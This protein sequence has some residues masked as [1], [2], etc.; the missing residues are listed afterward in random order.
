MP[1]K[2]R[3][4]IWS[5]VVCRRVAHRTYSMRDVDAAELRLTCTARGGGESPALTSRRNQSSEPGKSIPKFLSKFARL[6]NLTA[7]ER[8]HLILF[9]ASMR[10]THSLIRPRR[11]FLSPVRRNPVRGWQSSTTRIRVPLAP[12]RW[13]SM[14]N[15]NAGIRSNYPASVPFLITPDGRLKSSGM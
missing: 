15:C 9:V 13:Q 5:G 12:R 11:Y 1:A 10:S 8:R 4:S 14:W 7:W 2:R 6:N 3:R